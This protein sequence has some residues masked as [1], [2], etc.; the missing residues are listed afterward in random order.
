M[1]PRVD[2]VA[3]QSHC[4]HCGRALSP[5]KSKTRVLVTLA[6]GTLLARE[7]R[8]HCPACRPRPASAT[9]TT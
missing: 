7:I 2:F 4:P 8:K 5:Q 6:A 1:P 9:A 3:E